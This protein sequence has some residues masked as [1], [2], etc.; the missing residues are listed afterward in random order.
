MAGA[1]GGTAMTLD[2]LA[3]TIPEYTAQYHWTP[4]FSVLAELL[5]MVHH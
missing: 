2:D 4:I 3:R 5:V 1:G